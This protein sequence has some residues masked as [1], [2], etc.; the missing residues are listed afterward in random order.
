MY[1]SAH[2]QWDSVNSVEKEKDRL[3]LILKGFFFVFFLGGGLY[4]Y[5]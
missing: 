2:A 1:F 3:T 4:Q 5:E